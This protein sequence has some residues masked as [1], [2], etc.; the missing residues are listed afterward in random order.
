[1][2]LVSYD[3]CIQILHVRPLAIDFHV[4]IC[5]EF[6]LNIVSIESSPPK[7]HNQTTNGLLKIL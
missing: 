3:F 1:M 7:G 6:A 5:L 4:G 2:S